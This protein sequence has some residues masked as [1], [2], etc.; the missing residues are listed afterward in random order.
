MRLTNLIYK[1]IEHDKLVHFLLSG[2]LT[3]IL[4]IKI[5][6]ILLAVAIVLTLG[7][8]KEV[9]DYLSYKVFSFK[10]MIA[11][12]LGIILTVIIR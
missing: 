3:L 12:C 9:I 5:D 1:Y 7:I 6:E 4:Y 8:I 2:Y 10:D 11:N